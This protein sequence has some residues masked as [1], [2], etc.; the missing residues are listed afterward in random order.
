MWRYKFTAGQTLY[1]GAFRN[2]AGSYIV[3]ATFGG[4][5]PS[6]PTLPANGITLSASNPTA[7]ITLAAGQRIP[8]TVTGGYAIVSTGNNGSCDPALFNAATGG[9]RV[10]DEN[11]GGHNWQFR[12]APGQI[13]YL[14]VYGNGA[15]SYTVTADFGG[16]ITP[17]DPPET[18]FYEAY[19]LE[20]LSLINQARAEAGV[21]AIKLN[22]LLCEGADIRAEE[23]SVSGS[24]RPNG[25]Q[26]STIFDEVGYRWVGYS[27]SQATGKESAAEA[28]EYF[29][30]SPTNY[31]SLINPNYRHIGIGY[32]HERSTSWVTLPNGGLA[33]TVKN[34]NNW[35]LLLAYN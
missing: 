30:N 17:S 8:I 19:A 12:F 29:Y 4:T 2:T 22:S 1:A 7:R 15:G 24:L 35:Y 11:S 28:F 27:L 5:T 9:A 18:G 26:A 31:K 25:T 14:G 32:Y 23:I 6:N 21:P 3:T 10:A 20:M 13:Y 33:T 16:T 34:V